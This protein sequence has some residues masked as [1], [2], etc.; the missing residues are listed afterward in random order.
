MKDQN[1][2]ADQYALYD[3]TYLFSKAMTIAEVCAALEI[4]HAFVGDVKASAKAAEKRDIEA[5]A[6]IHKRSRLIVEWATAKFGIPLGD[7]LAI[8]EKPKPKPTGNR[9]DTA[10]TP[11]GGEQLLPI[12]SNCSEDNTA[13]AMVNILSKLDEIT[14]ALSRVCGAIINL[15]NCMVEQQKIITHTI[16]VNCDIVA[17]EVIRNKEILDGIKCNTRQRKEQ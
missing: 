5:L 3:K 11:P 15:Q 9:P 1:K 7:V 16:D 4:S 14:S 12:A 17:Q 13:Q 8:E 6:K 2:I 10:R